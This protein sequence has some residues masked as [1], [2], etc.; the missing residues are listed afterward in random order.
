MKHRVGALVG[1]V[2]REDVGVDVPLGL[3]AHPAP[4]RP[5]A[6]ATRRRSRSTTRPT[7]CAS[8]ATCSATSTSTPSGSRPASVHAA[9]SAAKNDLV[10]VDA[11]A[12]RRH[13]HL[14]A[15]DRRR[16]PRVP[17]PPAARP[18]PWTSTTCW[19]TPSRC[20][21]EH[22]DVLEH[23]RSRFQHVLVDEYQDTNRVQNELVVA[24]GRASTATSASWATPTSRST[25]SAAPTSATS[26]SSRRRS[27][28]PPS[29][30][31]EQNYR[32]TQTILDAANA[33]IANNLGRKPKE[34]WTDQGGGEPIVRYHADDETD[35]A[36]W[37]AHEI[38]APARRRR[39]TAGATWPS[40]TGP[41]PRAG[42]SRSTLMRVGIPYKV[43]G[44]TRFYDRREVKDALAYLQAVVNPV[45]EVSRQAGAQ[46]ARSGA[47]ATRTVGR[48]DAWA[49][50]HGVHLHR[51][52]APGRRGRRQRPGACRGID[53]VPR[54]ARR[55][56][57]AWS[58]TG[59]A[60]LLEA[61]ARRAAATSPSW[62][63]STSIEAEGR[64]ENLAE[65]VGAARE[66]DDG[67]RVPRAGQPGGRHR[68]ARRRRLVA[69]CS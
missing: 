42:C 41:T 6:S 64:L 49:T 16:L 45:D 18:A 1:P 59:P 13:G 63:P 40:S 24:A 54:P 38:A 12:D 20:S 8:P 33:V 3:R 36:Q 30:V 53:D 47:S 68:R 29:I 10:G 52:P 32:S 39:A 34:L 25:A 19:S 15:P 61:A 31:L 65:L 5:T 56:G 62:R 57:R 9:I 43:I 35:E 23:Y 50:G 44:G 27:P 4:R 21:S 60:P 67:R 55:A 14:R 17:G 66:F 46:R 26:S 58:P 28:T 37:V 11:Y 2:A 51:R 7:P 69:S 48:L 22:P